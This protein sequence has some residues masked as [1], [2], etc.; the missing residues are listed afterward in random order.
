MHIFLSFASLST[1]HL[2]ARFCRPFISI[3]IFALS[4]LTR[5]LLCLCHSHCLRVSFN[6]F[7]NSFAFE[8]TTEA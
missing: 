3:N 4:R 2:T 7:G 8:G 6:R 5:V 1:P